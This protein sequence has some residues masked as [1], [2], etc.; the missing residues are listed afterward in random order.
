MI[1][2]GFLVVDKPPGVTSHDI[3]AVVRAVTGLQKVGHTGTLDPFATGV[4][5]LALGS[6]TRLIQYLDEREKVYDA[7]IRLGSLTDTGDPTGQVVQEAPV[8]A[9]TRARVLEVLAGFKGPRMQV[10][11][12][13]SAVKVNGRALYDYA[14]KGEVVEVQ[15]RPIEIYGM[16][17]LELGDLSLRVHI[18]CSRGTYA[19]VIAEEVGEALGTVAHLEALRRDAS[20]SFTLDQGI[21]MA[22]IAD[23]VAGDPA[24]DRVLK[25]SRDGAARTP[26]RPRAE[27]FAGISAWVLP[28]REALRHLPAVTLTPLDARKLQQ[29]GVVPPLPG[30]LDS[31]CL[32]LDGDTIIGVAPPGARSVTPL[33]L[34]EEGARRSGPDRRGGH[35]RGGNDRRGRGG[36][37]RDGG[38][39]EERAAEG[40][41]GASSE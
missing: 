35:G 40:S 8:P 23:I 17:L 20:G 39:R 36:P 37:R 22:R 21:S 27:V 31:A 7:T 19:R 28:S 30:G 29:T 26:W 18:R 4:L 32:L 10:P 3:V 5:P 14:R 41:G 24:W 9:F 1:R 13:Y 33:A 2:D 38:A 15:A 11:P 12:R 34:E 16:E 25:P 6:A